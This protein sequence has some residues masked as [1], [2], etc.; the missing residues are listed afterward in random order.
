MNKKNILYAIC[1]LIATAVGIYFFS[2]KSDKYTIAKDSYQPLPNAY[3]GS[4]TCKECHQK[5]YDEWLLSDH[6]KAMQHATPETVLGNFDNVTYTADGITSRFFRKNN[7]FYI[8]T[9]G[10]QG[11]YKDY[12]VIYTFGHYPLQQYLTKFD[13]GKMQVFR[14]SWDSREG[15]WFHQYAGEKIPADDYLHWTNAGQNWN[16]MCATCHSTNLQ[17]NLNPIN[18][19][20]N[21][22]Y[23]ELT[24]GCESCHGKGKQHSEFMRSPDYITG[25]S[26]QFYIDLHK[27]TTQTEELNTCM[28]CHSRRGEVSQHHFSSHEIMDNYIPEVPVKNLYF[29][30][31]QALDEVYKY[32]SFLQSKMFQAHIKCSNCHSAHTGKVKE[33]GNKLCLQCHT[34]H[35]ASSAHTFHKEN[36]DASDCRFCHMPTR[37]YMGNDIRHDHNFAVPRPDLSEKYGVPNACNDCH[38]DKS[39]KWAANAVKQWYGTTRKPHFAEDLILGSMQNAQSIHHLN[40]LLTNSTTPNIVRAA[41]VYYLSGIYTEQSLSLLKKELNNRDSQTRYRAVI[42][43]GN[44]PIHLYE[45]EL[46]PLFED[47]VKAVRIATANVFLMQ[48]GLQWSENNLISFKSAIKEYEDFV[49]SQSD[50]PLGSATAGD[51]YA[52]TNDIAKAILFYERATKKDKNLN[53]VRLNLATLYSKNKRND[54][55]DSILKKAIT[56]EPKNPQIFYFMALL[57]SEEGN[58][59]QAKKYFEQAIALGMD[60]ENVRKNYQAVLQLI[61]NEKK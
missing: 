18:D 17:K 42:A 12:E 15:K 7:R 11:Q 41:A 9:E 56:Y 50:F 6:F 40:A 44:F 33:Q 25:V 38:T 21:T 54:K 10:E 58:Y 35:Y 60:N 2:R 46:I 19:T 52:Q 13:G 20:Y 4:Q 23:S 1:I 47:K 27:N 34:T 59:R 36:T 3:V 51:Y 29:A 57:N 28:P 61:N 37:T 14:Q 55:A 32:S 31:G 45:K 43:L 22:S 53:H 49:L 8:N 26:K 16:L 48:K 5:E 30:D 24:V 39:P